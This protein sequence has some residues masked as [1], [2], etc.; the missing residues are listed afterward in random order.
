MTPVFPLILH[1]FESCLLREAA[2][3]IIY[4]YGRQSSRTPTPTHPFSLSVSFSLSHFL[5]LNLT[6]A[7]VL[8]S[9]FACPLSQYLLSSFALSLSRA[10]SRFRAL[11]QSRFF[12]LALALALILS[13]SLSLCHSRFVTFSLSLSDLP[14]PP[15]YLDRSLSLFRCLFFSLPKTPQPPKNRMPNLSFRLYIYFLL[16]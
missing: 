11:S 8:S 7:L 5:R 16:I 2:E 10:L 12:A 3:C 13:I 9:L 15:E 4:L 1:F 14:S 6:R